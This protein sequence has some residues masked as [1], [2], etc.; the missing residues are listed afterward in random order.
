[1]VCCNDATKHNRRAS[2]AWLFLSE[3]ILVMFVRRDWGGSTTCGSMSAPP[4]APNHDCINPA[5]D[6]DDVQTV[7][8]AAEDFYQGLAGFSGEADV[9]AYYKEDL[10]HYGP[11]KAFESVNDD[12]AEAD[13]VLFM[14]NAPWRKRGHGM[15]GEGDGGSRRTTPKGRSKVEAQPT[16]DAECKLAE[17]RSD[18]D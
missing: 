1:M 15:A 10:M 2:K 3:V 4:W 13:E 11:P 8:P 18:R 7:I 6:G 12:Q 17:D 16:A 14:M 9:G 5:L